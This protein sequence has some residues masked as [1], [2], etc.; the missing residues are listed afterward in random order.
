MVGGGLGEGREGFR[1]KKKY[2]EEEKLFK[3]IF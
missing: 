1:G 2:F 3:N